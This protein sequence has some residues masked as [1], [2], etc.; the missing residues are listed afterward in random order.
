MKFLLHQD[1]FA[2]CV[3]GH[4]LGNGRLAQHRQE[5]AASAA[6]VMGLDLWLTRRATPLADQQI[7]LG[8]LAQLT[9]L[10]VDEEVAPRAAFFGGRQRGVQPKLTTLDLMVVATALVHNLTLV[11][12]NPGIFANVPGLTAVDWL[13]P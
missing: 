13:V 1:C 7:Y 6:S 8:M 9:V 12:H 2:A 4:R 10:P 5:V 11:T 3:R